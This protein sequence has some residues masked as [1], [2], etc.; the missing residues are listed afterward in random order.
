MFWMNFWV[1]LFGFKIFSYFY[2]WTVITLSCLTSMTHVNN[3]ENWQI[4]VLF[5]SPSIFKG[6]IATLR[7]Q[8]SRTWNIMREVNREICSSKSGNKNLHVHWCPKRIQFHKSGIKLS[9]YDCQQG[10]NYF[11]PALYTTELCP[12]RPLLVFLISVFSFPLLE[13][14]VPTYKF[15]NNYPL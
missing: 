7:V 1:I 5:L 10:W 11:T 4:I 14:M 15:L 3:V 13:L 9:H 12:E 8:S 2:Y 6:W